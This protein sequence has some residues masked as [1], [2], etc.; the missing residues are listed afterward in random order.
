[1]A[2][3]R[4]RMDW[5]SVN[6]DWNQ[7]R[8]FLITAE[9]GSLSAAARALGTTQPTLSRQVAA[10]E[11]ELGLTLFER[12]GKGIILTAAG[13]QLLEY[14]KQMGAA[15]GLFSLASS[16]QSQSLEGTVC[17][18]ASEI[19]AMLRLP[20]IVKTIQRLEPCIQI[21]IVATNEPSD[22][23]RR[24]ADIAIR[25][26]RPTQG[27]LIAKKLGEERIWFFGSTDYLSQ[28]EGMPPAEIFPRLKIIGFEQS[29]RLIEAVKDSGWQIDK[30]NI[31]IIT[32]SHLVHWQL[33][34][35][36]MGLSL[37]PEE[38][39]HKEK[40]LQIAIAE[41]GPP[42]TLPLWLICHRELRT[43]PRVRRVFDILAENLF[44]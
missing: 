1:M 30:S 24:E 15:A 33:V 13:T 34:K 43:N 22:L 25:S 9:E 36:G 3:I 23:K 35:E 5:S 38:I 7:V 6:F 21:E 8:A 4:I 26:F 42:M 28:F 19:D 41:L 32:A 29:E 27:D 39:A 44:P 11:E 37:F 40:D 2:H 16:G 31:S 20:D 14:A 12:V 10:L 17:I 18:S